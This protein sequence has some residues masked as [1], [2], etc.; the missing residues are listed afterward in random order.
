MEL[1]MVASANKTPESINNAKLNFHIVT[2]DPILF[3]NLYIYPVE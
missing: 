3:Y 1:K 2:Y